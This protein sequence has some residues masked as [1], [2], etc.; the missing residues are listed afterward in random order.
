M[1][2][3]KVCSPRKKI[4]I[5]PI[6]EPPQMIILEIWKIHLQKKLYPYLIIH[7]IGMRAQEKLHLT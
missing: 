3:W 4:P 2:I 7:L 5:K 1:N 6:M